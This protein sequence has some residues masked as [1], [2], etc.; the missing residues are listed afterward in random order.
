MCVWLALAATLSALAVAEPAHATPRVPGPLAAVSDTDPA[1]AVHR[2][3]EKSGGWA[4][5][6]TACTPARASSAW[7]AGLGFGLASLAAA[8]ISR[9]RSSAIP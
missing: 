1:P 3:S 8:G 6:A 4:C 2:A 7:S 9:R 5:S